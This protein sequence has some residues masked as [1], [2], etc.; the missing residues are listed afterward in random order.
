MTAI[1]RGP[2]MGADAVCPVPLAMRV[3]T[4]TPVTVFRSLLH[5]AELAPEMLNSGRV[6]QLPALTLTMAEIIAAVGRAGGQEAAKRITVRPNAELEAILQ[7]MP[8]A[9]SAARARALGFPVA[10]IEYHK[11]GSQLPRYFVVSALCTVPSRH[12]RLAA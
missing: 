1:V 8:P 7:G 9:F 5:A 11:A 4:V 10:G 3:G 2:L 6:V 12:G